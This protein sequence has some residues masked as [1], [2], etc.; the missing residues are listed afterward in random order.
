MPNFLLE[1]GTEE[2]PAIFV[3]EAIEQWKGRIPQS[4]EEQVL[5]PQTIEYYGTPRRL[6]VLI[7]GLPSQQSDRSEEIK[8]PPATA[9]FKDGQPT[10]AA[11]GFANKQGVDVKDFSVRE[12]DKGAFVFV[13]KQ[14]IGRSVREILKELAPHWITG[15]EGRRFMRWG[16]GDLRFP[17]PIRHL[18]A[19]L[20]EE[21]L[22]IE[23]SSGSISLKSDRIS[24]GHRILHPDPVVIPQASNYLA[25]LHSAYVEAEPRER[26]HKI[27]QQI[28]TA[29]KQLN[30]VAEISPDLLNEVTNLVEYPTAVI[31]KF[32]EAFLELPAEVIITVMVTHQRYFP[33][34]KSPK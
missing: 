7:K 34:K 25:C 29:A 12:T 32:D 28:A 6:A 13:R 20:D 26:R 31:G 10:K 33:V 1:I 23:L 15:L 22:P 3:D 19:L 17:R 27:Q 18:V 24:T 14:I 2:L 30:G 4:L 11:I 5:T 9:A 8:G 21:I 16:D